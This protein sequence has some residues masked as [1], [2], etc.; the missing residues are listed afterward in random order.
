MNLLNWLIA[1]GT[2]KPVTTHLRSDRDCM[3]ESFSVP[4]DTFNY[5]RGNPLG[6]DVDR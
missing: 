4:Y 6:K 5:S 1:G 2:S 3:S